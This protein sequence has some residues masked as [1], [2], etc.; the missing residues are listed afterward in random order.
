MRIERKYFFKRSDLT[1]LSLDLKIICENINTYKV[2]SIYFDNVHEYAYFQ[3]IEGEKDKIKIRARYY[4]DLYDYINLEAKIKKSD[5]S[6][7]LKAKL[8]ETELSLL[9]KNNF[10]DLHNKDVNDDISKIY[11]Y[12]KYYG[13]QR[14][15]DIE[16]KRIE[17]ILK[18]QDKIRLTIDYDIFSSKNLFSVLGINKLRCIPQDL[19]VLEI[20]SNDGFVDGLVKFILEKYRM[21]NAAIS[22]Y[23]LGLQIQKLN[24]GKK[25][26]IN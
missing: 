12:Y 2:T 7:K 21:R 6:Y 17:M 15:I 26:G 18:N 20:K 10:I 19:C 1:Q 11:Y 3:K 4:N 9:L 14:N 23:A 22:K 25:Y 8:T 13:M 16:Y 5:K 24:M